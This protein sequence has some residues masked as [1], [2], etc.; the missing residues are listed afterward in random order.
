MS[1]LPDTDIRG[2]LAE[3]LRRQGLMPTERRSRRV[4]VRLGERLRLEYD[5]EQTSAPVV[6]PMYKDTWQA[7][8]EVDALLGQLRGDTPAVQDVLAGMDLPT[9]G[10]FGQHLHALS[11]LLGEE[12]IRKARG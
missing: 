8:P 2:A 11:V 5:R 9:L 12:A 1:E 7:G 3:D 6:P 10:A 4:E